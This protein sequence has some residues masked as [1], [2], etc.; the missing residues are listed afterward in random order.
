MFSKRI[1][2]APLNQAFEKYNF[3]YIGPKNE[4]PS[5]LMPFGMHFIY[6]ILRYSV[7]KNCSI[8]DQFQS[9][10]QN[11]IIWGPFLVLY[12]KMLF[13]NAWLRG[14]NLIKLKK[15]ICANVLKYTE[16]NEYEELL[17]TLKLLQN[18]TPP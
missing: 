16:P 1:K 18:Y 15:L 14:G 13:S 11:T 4:S 2:F 10:G 8:D 3:Y 6:T 9:Y 5:N 17:E 7:K 12:S